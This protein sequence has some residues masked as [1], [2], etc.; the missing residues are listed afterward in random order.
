VIPTLDQ[1]LPPV[2]AHLDSSLASPEC[3]LAL[4]AIAQR[5]PAHATSLFGFESRLD[6]N[7]ATLDFLVHVDSR[8]G[9]HRVLADAL[10]RDEAFAPLRDDDVWRRVGEFARLWSTPGSTPDVSLDRDVH[11]MWLEFDVMPGEHLPRPS[12]F[13]APDLSRGGRRGDASI[14]ATRLLRG[15]DLLE[16]QAQRIASCLD[17]LPDTAGLVH[18]G[19]MLSRP[20]DA[21]RLCIGGLGIAGIPAYL[22]RLGREADGLQMMRAIDRWKPYISRA[23]LNLDV[24][25]VI[26]PRLALE[27]YAPMEPS[28]QSVLVY[29]RQ[30]WRPFFDELVDAGLCTSARADAL[31][32]YVGMERS[33]PDWPPL[34]AGDP[35]VLVRHINHVKLQ[36]QSGTLAAKAYLAARYVRP[37][38]RTA[39]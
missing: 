31:L 37:N 14:A 5:L 10:T 38:N 30:R 32:A 12:V 8:S 39:S 11:A 33:T 13:I 3:R 21:L 34:F 36:F 28:S 1:R 27:C 2:L 15:R 22:A 20:G 17:A 7:A 6:D 26:A 35:H 24:A 9:G 25:D 4:H 16:E 23:Y 18:I 29:E 19:M